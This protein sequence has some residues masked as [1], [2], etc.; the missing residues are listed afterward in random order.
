M[1]GDDRLD[2]IAKPNSN[3]ELVLPIAH[4]ALLNSENP[5]KN[6]LKISVFGLG[7][8]IAIILIDPI[9]NLHSM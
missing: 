3:G 8:C 4:Y 2:R 7:S 6:S 1:P 9:K 5:Y